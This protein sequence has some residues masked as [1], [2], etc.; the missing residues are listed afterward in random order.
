MTLFG[1]AA[2]LA[3]VVG[4]TLGGYITDNY[5]W[6]WIF[7]SECPGWNRRRVDVRVPLSA[8]PITWSPNEPGNAAQRRP[9]DTLG[10]C[11]LSVAMICCGDR[12]QQ[13]SGVG[14]G[15]EIPSGACRR[16]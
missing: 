6:R 12:A 9:F 7:L 16:C 11:L 1:M 15:W 13:R 8:I 3:P 4:P 5:G 10:L 14:F 2:L